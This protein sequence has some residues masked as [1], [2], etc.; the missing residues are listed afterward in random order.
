MVLLV[1][2]VIGFVYLSPERATRF[3]VDAERQRS[4]LVRKEI[5]L[6]G[7]LHFVY[8]DGGQG[9][10]LM[11]LH[12][13]GANKDN[14][15]RVARFLTP[16][17]RVIVPDE[18]GFGDAALLRRG[19]LRPVRSGGTAAQLAQALGIKRIHL[20]AVRWAVKSP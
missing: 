3:V 5:D 7:G 13:F 1:V 4:G 11:L 18:I 12:G 2:G 8:L 14:F 9:E 20:G 6:P 17:Y 19:R 10:P 15:V 16:H